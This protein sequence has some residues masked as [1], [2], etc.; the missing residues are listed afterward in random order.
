MSLPEDQ[1]EEGE[2]AVAVRVVRRV[3]SCKALLC[4]QVNLL[5]AARSFAEIGSPHKNNLDIRQKLIARK[6]HAEVL[7]TKAEVTM[8]HFFVLKE[9]LEKPFG[10]SMATIL[11]TPA[12]SAISGISK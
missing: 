12:L 7:A 10:E 5:M 6:E 1:W 8:I 2:G 9:K 3:K 4:G 11:I